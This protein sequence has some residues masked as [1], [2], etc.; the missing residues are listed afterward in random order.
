MLRYHGKASFEEI[1]TKLVMKPH[2]AM[3]IHTR[4]MDKLRESVSGK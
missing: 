1:G 4:T 3:T 2:T